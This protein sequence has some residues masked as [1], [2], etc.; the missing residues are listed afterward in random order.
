MNKIILLL[1][2][3]ITALLAC[4]KKIPHDAVVNK[5]AGKHVW[6]GTE[7]W[8]EFFTHN[9]THD[10]I[11]LSTVIYAINTEAVSY[12]DSASLSV[13]TL[14]YT[15]HNINE[16]AIYFEENEYSSYNSMKY[17]YL[18]DS[19]FWERHFIKNGGYTRWELQSP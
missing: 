17:Y 13:I 5:M 1:A 10:S 19:F 9:V 14:Y 4:K 15:R 3:L 16:K 7:R 8:E 12:F 2:F 18:K 11:K 6:M